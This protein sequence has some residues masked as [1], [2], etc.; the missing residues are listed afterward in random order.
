MPDPAPLSFDE[1]QRRSAETAVYPEAGRNLAYPTLGLAGETG[2]VAEKVKKVLRDHG[3][4]VSEETRAALRKE[5]GDVLWYVAALC[6]ELRL[7]LGDVAAAN[8]EKLFSR[9]ER[10]V[11]RGSGDER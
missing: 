8:L 7:D 5:L 6:R 11:L 2:E 3:G 1:Y 9:K 4:T 10:G